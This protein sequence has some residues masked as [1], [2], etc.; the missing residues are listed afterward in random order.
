M[1][2]KLAR[3]ELEGW[4]DVRHSENLKCLAAELKVR[5]ARTNFIVAE[6]GSAAQRM[7]HEA[8]TLAKMGTTGARLREIALDIPAGT[9][10][11]GIRL[12][13]NRQKTSYRGIREVKIQALE[14][15]K[16]TN[17]KL[18]QVRESLKT[19][20]NKLVTDEE[21]WRSFRDKT[22]LPRTSQFLWRAMHN[23]HRVG[24]Y[25]T[26]IPEC[27]DRAICQDCGEEEDLEHFLL[28][29][30][31][32]GAGFIWKAA[33]KLWKEKEPEW[34]ELSLGS[35]LGCGLVNFKDED[36]KQKRGTRC[37]YKILISESAYMIWKIRNDRVISRSGEPLDE[38]AILNKWIFNLN[39]RLQQDVMLANRSNKGNRPHL[40]PLLV[41]ESWSGILDDEDKLPLNWLKESRVLVGR[42]ALTQ[43]QLHS[44]GVG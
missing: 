14:P 33:E 32:P 6:Q 39:Q 44:R 30:K 25:W 22:F 12:E 21:I 29:C 7:G 37:L 17:R 40:A 23:A 43:D 18:K 11:T 24:H 35:I 3:Y 28:Q 9:K 5:K 1:T 8:S 31:S 16:S 27:E 4:V 26:H 34:P 41:K 2:K 19:L 38:A 20:R 13:G 36:G 15:R 10:L 42:R